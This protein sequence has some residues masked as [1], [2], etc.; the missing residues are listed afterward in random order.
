MKMPPK[1]P[2]VL[3]QHSAPELF[4]A[5]VQHVLAVTPMLTPSNFLD[6]TREP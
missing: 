3:V 6:S 5:L 2:R 1:D 4:A